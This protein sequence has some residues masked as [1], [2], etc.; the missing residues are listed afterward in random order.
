MFRSTGFGVTNVIEVDDQGVKVRA[1]GS[2]WLAVV[3]SEMESA[4]SRARP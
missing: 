4:R 3:V 2:R 1:L